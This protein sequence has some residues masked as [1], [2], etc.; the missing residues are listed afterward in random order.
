MSVADPNPNTGEFVCQRIKENETKSVRVK[1]NNKRNYTVTDIHL[2]KWTPNKQTCLIISLL[3]QPL[4]N[5]KS[6]RYIATKIRAGTSARASSVVLLGDPIFSKNIICIWSTRSLSQGLGGI[7]DEV[8]RNWVE[9]STQTA[10][11][12]NRRVVFCIFFN[13]T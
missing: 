13:T 8:W 3:H 5:C 10:D 11:T 1:H 2:F 4:I 9:P 6:S 7:Y 12:K